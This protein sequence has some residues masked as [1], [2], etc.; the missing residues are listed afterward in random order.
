[1]ENTR[2][3]VVKTEYLDP[4]Q[5]APSMEVSLPLTLLEI[6]KHIPSYSWGEAEIK[7][8]LKIENFVQILDCI[9]YRNV[10]KLD[11]VDAKVKGEKRFYMYDSELGTMEELPL[12]PKSADAYR[13]NNM[14][15]E[16]TMLLQSVSKSYLKAISPEY[17][18]AY[19]VGKAYLVR[20]KEEA[21]RK[22]AKRIER[23]KKREVEKAKKVLE[24]E[25]LL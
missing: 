2:F 25:G 24:K 10:K 6:L 8:L 14:A 3:I 9:G 23:A 1:M 5:D 13:A 7:A 15:K 19:E 12:D 17:A 16:S 21:E 11:A 22:E 20:E 18:K 4:Y